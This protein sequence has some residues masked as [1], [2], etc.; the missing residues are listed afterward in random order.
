MEHTLVIPTY[1]RPENLQRLLRYLECN[2]LSSRVLVLDS[3]TPDNIRKNQSI[4]DNSDLE[5]DHR[6]FANDIHPFVKMNEGLATVTTDYCSACADDDLIFVPSLVEML[7]ALAQDTSL[8]ATHGT[9]LNFKEEE[10]FFR[11]ISVAQR[12]T[13]TIAPGAL[14]RVGDFLKDYNV[15]FYAVYRTDVM[16]ACFAPMRKMKTTL[17]REIASSALAVANGPVS[18][19]DT[20][21]MARNTDESA[22]Y[23]AWHPHQIIASNPSVLFEDYGAFRQLLVDT[24][25]QQDLE[26]DRPTGELIDLMCLRYIGPFLREDVLDFIMNERMTLGHNS[27]TTIDNLW[28]TFVVT[29]NR[30]Q[31]KQVPLFQDETWTFSPGVLHPNAPRQDYLVS[32]RGP[33]NDRSYFLNNEFFFPDASP[34]CDISRADAEFILDQLDNY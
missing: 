7:D 31:H 11:I 8:A 10:D 15:L 27:Q 6:T 18:R 14:S 1:N 23:D 4:C 22:S 30:T 34:R 2:E 32:E 24:V 33:E 17:L 25:D 19:L 12:N 26:N 28:K 5:T 20:F 3:S 21:Y 9:Y 16:K 29:P 13:Q